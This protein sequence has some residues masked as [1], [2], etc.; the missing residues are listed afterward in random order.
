MNGNTQRSDSSMIE[1]GT[2]ISRLEAHIEALESRLAYQEHWLDTLDR[3]AVQQ[4]Q[5]LSQLER[6]NELM[7]Q[8]L[9]DQNQ[10]LESLSPEPGASD[11]RPPH[12]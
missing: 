2:L 10:A 9:R 7:Q 6:M 3:A 5:R 4:E 8:R 12:Y 1:N 11:E